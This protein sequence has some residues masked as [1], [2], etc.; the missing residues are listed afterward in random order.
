MPLF[1]GSCQP[2]GQIEFLASDEYLGSELISEPAVAAGKL[3][4]LPA[5]R[6][7]GLQETWLFIL[8]YIVLPLVVWISSIQTLLLRFVAEIYLYGVPLLLFGPF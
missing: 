1:G 3:Y 6:V 8:E 2:F 5:S 7:L 4:Q